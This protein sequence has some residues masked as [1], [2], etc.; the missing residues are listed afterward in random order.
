MDG[1]LAITK[2]LVEVRISPRVSWRVLVNDTIFELAKHTAREVEYTGEA[3]PQSEIARAVGRARFSIWRCRLTRVLV[4][5]LLA[6]AVKHAVAAWQTTR[7]EPGQ[8]ARDA[9]ADEELLVSR[10]RDSLTYSKARGAPLSAASAGER[11]HGTEAAVSWRPTR[12]KGEPASGTHPVGAGARRRGGAPRAVNLSRD[13]RFTTLV[14]VEHSIQADV[15][16]ALRP[17]A[18]LVNE[19]ERGV[20]QTIWGIGA[21]QGDQ[22]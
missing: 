16:A 14:A 8:S 9:M 10:V 2:S 5:P 12:G 18:L 20:A 6:I 7:A 13:F 1:E 15:P 19:V 4:V 22:P 11:V 3:H 17:A 21:P